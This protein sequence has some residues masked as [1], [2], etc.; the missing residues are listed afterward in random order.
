MTKCDVK[1]VIS[2]PEEERWPPSRTVA[3]KI[4]TLIKAEV[5]FNIAWVSK[6]EN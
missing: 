3:L 4:E 5:I 6:I 1:L 2:R